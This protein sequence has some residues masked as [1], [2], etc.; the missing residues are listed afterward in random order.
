[1]KR[2]TR[3]V[4]TRG[5]SMNKL[6]IKHVNRDAA[7]DV[8]QFSI[9][10]LFALHLHRQIRIFDHH[11]LAVLHAKVT[12]LFL[13]IRLRHHLAR[14]FRAPQQMPADER[15]IDATHER[16]IDLEVAQCV[17]ALALHQ[18]ERAASLQSTQRAAMP[19]RRKRD[20]AARL[21]HNLSFEVHRRHPALAEEMHATLVEPEEPVLR[22]KRLRRRVILVARHDEPVQRP[23]VTSARRLDL[24][25]EN[26]KKRFL[27]ERRDGKRAFRSVVTETRPLPACDGERRHASRAKR[28]L[29]GRFGLR[30]IGRVAAVFRQGFVGRRRKA[31]EIHRGR[32][33]REQRAGQPF[34]FGEID[35]GGFLEQTAL[36]VGFQLVVERENVAL[37]GAFELL[38]QG[39]LGHA[40]RV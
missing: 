29:P 5:H 38:D 16:I 4:F 17:D 13:G 8:A 26:L 18:L 28:F 14:H 7:G 11:E 31:C 40:K 25:S 6:A 27:L 34:D 32:L 33:L 37:S 15:G 10:I 9:R 2:Q 35:L 24:F 22:E 20:R 1:M 21:Q 39:M 36:L 23:A 3:T 19:V 12:E 30:P